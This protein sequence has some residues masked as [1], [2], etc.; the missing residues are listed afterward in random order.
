MEMLAMEGVAFSVD[1]YLA[2]ESLL[3]PGRV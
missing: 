3:W 2:D 1:G